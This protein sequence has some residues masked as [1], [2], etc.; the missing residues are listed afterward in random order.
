MA[1]S[2]PCH[3]ADPQHVEAISGNARQ[4]FE[5]HLYKFCGAQLQ[6]KPPM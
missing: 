4:V 3:L 6:N 1:G 5:D 2:N